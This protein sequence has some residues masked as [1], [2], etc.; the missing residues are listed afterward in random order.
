MISPSPSISQRSWSSCNR[1]R[2]T[3]EQQYQFSLIAHIPCVPSSSTSFSECA[4]VD[5]NCTFTENAP[6]CTSWLSPCERR[7]RCTTVED[8]MNEA[9][10]IS[11]CS[12]STQ[13]PSPDSLCVA[14]NGSCQWYNPCRTW[15][16]HC[17]SGYQCGSES[18]YWA[19]IYGPHPLCA[20][21]P[22]GW[23]VP[24][25]PGECNI[26]NGHC[27]WTCKSANPASAYPVQKVH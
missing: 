25:P 5:G 2:C 27:N 11:N 26:Q 12:S 8:Y 18:D 23:Q 19:F 13:V 20:A 17:W 16:G 24:L 10:T 9:P 4:V 1:P 22:P 14:I 7:Y 15:Q 21:R 3:P 6:N